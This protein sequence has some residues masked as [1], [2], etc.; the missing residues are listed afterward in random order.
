LEE[1]TRRSNE[2]EGSNYKSPATIGGVGCASRVMG[3][4]HARFYEGLGHGDM[5]ESTVCQACS[6]TG[7]ESPYTT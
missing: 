3:N 6:T 7:G 2:T 5:P 4:Y 1:A